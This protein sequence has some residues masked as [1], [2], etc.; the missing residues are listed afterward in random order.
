MA[1]KG[2]WIFTDLFALRPFLANQDISKGSMIHLKG[3]LK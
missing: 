2:R 3:E 1:K